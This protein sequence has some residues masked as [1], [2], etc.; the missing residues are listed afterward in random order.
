METIEQF[1]QHKFNELPG[2]LEYTIGQ[3]NVF[4]IENRLDRKEELPLHVRRNFFKIMLFSG[5]NVFKYG[6]EEIKV[7]GNTLLFFHPDIPYSYQP[8]TSDTKG[9]FCVF[10]R[11]FFLGSHK[12]DVD[13]LSLFRSSVLPV[14]KLSTDD[15]KEVKNLFDKMFQE[16]NGN[17]IYKYDLIRNYASELYFLAMKWMPPENLF[18]YGDA[19][20]RITMVFLELLEQQFPIQYST[21]KLKFRLPNEF[22]E[23]ISIHVNYLNRCLKK[24][25]GK[26][27]S[28]HIM[29]RLSTEAKILLKHTD[30]SVSEISDSLGFDDLAHFNK[31]FKKQTGLNPTFFRL[32]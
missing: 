28:Q 1:Y 21:D 27:T 3:F 14:F 16:V 11:E 9:F 24:V 8:L 31:F 7:E 20:K 15:C 10:K 29:E 32:V 17:Y 19:S 6:N 22:A 18:Q 12:L 30:W 5:E 23:K 4:R 2:N 25:T 13:N 26:T